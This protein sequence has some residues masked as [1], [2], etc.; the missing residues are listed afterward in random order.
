[1]NGGA[2]IVDKP[3]GMTSHDVV[4]IMRK[5]FSTKRVG[6]T[7]TLDPQ[8]TGVLPV[9]VGQATKAADMISATDKRYLATLRLGVTTDTLDAWGEVT[10]T[11]EVNVTDE[12]IERVLCDFRGDILQIPPMYSAIKKDGKKLYELARAG[13]EIERQAREVTIHNLVMTGRDGDDVFLDVTCSKGTYIRTLCA[14]IGDRLSCGGLMAALRRVSHGCFDISQAHTVE[15]LREEPDPQ[16][17]LIPTDEL[18]SYPKLILTKRQ[19][20]LVKNGVPIYINADKGQYRVY[21]P[22]GEFLSISEAVEL[23][24]RLCLKLKKAFYGQKG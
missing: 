10:D 24:G 18:F 2:I 22:D 11:R 6:H 15:Q 12:E 16:R 21:A 17:F 13:K 4:A 8:A 7:G 9:L 3:A 14:D 5:V 1:M 23:E 20:E 19:A